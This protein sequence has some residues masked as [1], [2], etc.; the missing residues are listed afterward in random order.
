MGQKQW[1]ARP[2][3]VFISHRHYD[4]PIADV[5]RNA[6]RTCGNGQLRVFQSSDA[7]ENISR[8]GQGLTDTQ[9][10]ALSE[11][12]VV[13][14]I[15]TVTDHDWYN[16]MWECGLATDPRGQGTKIVVFRGA[17]DVPASL[18]DLMRVTLDEHSIKKFIRDFHK[19][20]TFFP[21]RDEAFDSDVDEKSII[22]ISHDFF[23]KLRGVCPRH[24]TV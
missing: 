7:R 12:D 24:R 18:R 15:Y 4:K 6:L 8:L 21:G 23:N 3:T 1:N 10:K 5:F 2:S 16:C 11:T 19:D 14:L 22:A 17:G 9:K 20:P 13:V